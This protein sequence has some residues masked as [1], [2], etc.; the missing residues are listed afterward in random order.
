MYEA[1]SL[2][3]VREKSIISILEKIRYQQI[4]RMNA[5]REVAQRWE[6]AFDP[7]VMN[8]VEKAKADAKFLQA[9]YAESEKFEVRNRDGMG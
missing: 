9:D 1:S 7:R 3:I 4:L 8:V 5:K 2:L 6:H